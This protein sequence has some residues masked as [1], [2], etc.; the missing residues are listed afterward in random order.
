MNSRGFRRVTS[1]LYVYSHGCLVQQQSSARS[2]RSVWVAVVGGQR[3]DGEHHA[4]A[5]A[6]RAVLTALAA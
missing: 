3:L 1:A 5:D 4:R 2:R 6:E